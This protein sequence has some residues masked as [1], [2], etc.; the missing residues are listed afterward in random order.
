MPCLDPDAWKNVAQSPSAQ[1]LSC[2]QVEAPANFGQLGTR[3][4][5]ET[6]ACKSA[7]GRDRPYV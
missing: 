4:P 2:T 3:W 1:G 6:Y 7:D 5:Q